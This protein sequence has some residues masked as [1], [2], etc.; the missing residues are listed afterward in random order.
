[1][2]KHMPRSI[3]SIAISSSISALSIPLER[4][5]TEVRT[6]G[7]P[8][9]ES[10][11]FIDSFPTRSDH[12]IGNHFFNPQDVAAPLHHVEFL[13]MVFHEV[14]N[15]GKNLKILRT[16]QPKNRHGLGYLRAEGEHFLFSAH[17][18]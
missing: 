15:S 3:S 9:P 8:C 13:Q 4:A 2:P 1:M 17:L 14:Q 6:R 7:V 12:L 11:L 16:A 18:L 5:T 10:G